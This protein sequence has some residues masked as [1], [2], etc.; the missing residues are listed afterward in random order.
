[1]IL[2]FLMFFKRIKNKI[3]LGF[4]FGYDFVFS[5]TKRT[6]AKSSFNDDIFWWVKW[7]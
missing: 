1:M 4:D 5:I 2:T 3:A 7:V 6:S